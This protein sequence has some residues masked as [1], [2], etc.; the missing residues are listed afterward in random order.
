[1]WYLLNPYYIIDYISIYFGKLDR[2]Y[3]SESYDDLSWSLLRTFMT[4]A[5]K[6]EQC[7]VFLMK[8][9]YGIVLSFIRIL[10]LIPSD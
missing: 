4:V 5:V 2:S 7:T 9:A 6:V 8:H 3:V 1:M 10:L